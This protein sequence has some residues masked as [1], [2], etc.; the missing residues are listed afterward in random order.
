[1]DF[2]EG[3]TESGNLSVRSLRRQEQEKGN[4]RLPTGFPFLSHNFGSSFAES[5]KSQFL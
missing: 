2:N 5:I 4:H 1:M 3:K